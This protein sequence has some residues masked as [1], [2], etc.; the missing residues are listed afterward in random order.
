MD[1]ENNR[2]AG[3]PDSA[4]AA[5]LAGGCFW[6]I[7]AAF[8][9]RKGIY[10]SVSGYAGGTQADAEYYTVVSGRTQHR[11][12][13]RLYFNPDE[14]SYE[15]ILEIFWQQ[16]DPTDPGGQFADRGH[17]YTTAIF[18]HNEAQKAAAEVS[19]KKV[20]ES[21]R[22]DRPV[23]TE[24]LP[25][26]TFFPAEEEHQNFAAKRAAYYQMYKKGSGRA[27][28]IESNWSKG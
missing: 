6:C 9:R 14:I 26:T 5:T 7:D 28:F 10:A 20:V 24:I 2:Q 17:Q 22:F 8:A 12:S 19:L 18:Y 1:L 27:D 3:V 11:E 21:G 15:E 23:A 13:V 4:E 16:I 25:V